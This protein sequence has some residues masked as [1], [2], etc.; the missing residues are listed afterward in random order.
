[1][2]NNKINNYRSLLHYL[3]TISISP[4]GT[5]TSSMRE[6]FTMKGKLIVTTIQE[7]ASIEGIEYD[8]DFV[9]LS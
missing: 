6:V 4:G 8:V 7:S 1:M 5:T 3:A 2:H 9:L